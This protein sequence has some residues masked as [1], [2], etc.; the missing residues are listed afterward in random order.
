MEIVIFGYRVMIEKADKLIDDIVYFIHKRERLACVKY[1]K[2]N[3]FDM[4]LKEA[5]KIMDDAIFITDE[6]E[7]RKVLKSGLKNY[8]KNNS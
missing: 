6:K 2:Q 4:G 3:H 7:M 8:K 1:I 5:K